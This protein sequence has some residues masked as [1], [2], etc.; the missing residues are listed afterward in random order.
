MSLQITQ[1]SVV[2]DVILDLADEH[3]GITQSLKDGWNHVEKKIEKS[4]KTY[5]KEN[6][7]DPNKFHPSGVP[8]W[9]LDKQR[10]EI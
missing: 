10:G 2:I 6:P 7:V 3:W 9:L 5:N 1:V 4:I 8:S